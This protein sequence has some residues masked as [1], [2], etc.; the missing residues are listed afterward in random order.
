[1]GEAKRRVTIMGGPHDS[2]HVEIPARAT[3]ALLYLWDNKPVMLT[4]SQDP[5]RSAALYTQRGI[6]RD[7]LVYRADM[8]IRPQDLSQ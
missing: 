7:R 3:S 2:L 6:D 8:V 1:M 4:P 5:R